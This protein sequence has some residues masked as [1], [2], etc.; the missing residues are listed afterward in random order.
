MEFL[1]LIVAVAFFVFVASGIVVLSVR[2]D[3]GATNRKVWSTTIFM[4]AGAVILLAG[5]ANL[6]INL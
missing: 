6:L 5:G 4:L 1:E 3:K 2:G